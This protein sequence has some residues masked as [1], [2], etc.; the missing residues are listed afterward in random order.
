LY[1]KGF[2][3]SLELEVISLLEAPPGVEFLLMSDSPLEVVELKGGVF[4]RDEVD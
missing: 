3:K 1:R 4:T 2:S